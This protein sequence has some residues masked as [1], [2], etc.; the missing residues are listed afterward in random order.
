MQLK[1]APREWQVQ[2]FDAWAKCDWRG[3]VQVV[4]G[5]GKTVFAEHCMLRAREAFPA[6]RFLIVVPSRSLLDQWFVCLREELNLAEQD[7]AVF[8]SDSRPADFALANI[9]VINTARTRVNE[10]VQG[11]HPVMLI[12]DECHRAAS[13]ANAAA[14]HGPFVATLGL[15]ATPKREYDE[16]FWT[17]LVPQLGKIIYTYDLNQA[18]RDG[19][20][21]PFTLTNIQVPLQDD[22]QEEY[23]KLSQSIARAR[24]RAEDEAGEERIKQLLLQRARVSARARMRIPVTARLLDAHRGNR[25]MVFH[26]DIDDANTLRAVLEERGHSVTIYHSRLGSAL[27]RDNLWLYRQGIYDVLISCRA[28]DEGINIP[29]TQV[30]V[31]ASATASRRQRVQRLGRVLRP[32]KGKSSALI[33]SL[34]A[35]KAEEKR[36]AK[37]ALILTEASQIHWR[38]VVPTD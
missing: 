2:A 4:T 18:R 12:V 14:L 36:L 9:M 17:V 1:Y 6:L 23:K 26:E 34:Y 10:L 31:I 38:R 22:E 20:V 37:E 35:T 19:I 24:M 33:Y 32:A 16:R 21:A 28:L 11:G 15:S 8:S 3:I 27:R 7:I 13:P 5:G 30:A 29:E 25:T